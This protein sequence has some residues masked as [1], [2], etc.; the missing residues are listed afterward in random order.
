MSKKIKKESL[1]RLFEK[2]GIKRSTGYYHMKKYLEELEGLGIIEV[3]KTFKN[4]R[5]YVLDE[6][7][8]WDYLK[9]KGFNV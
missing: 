1:W 7:R 9:E 8:F 3:V 4:K 6:N 5:I 2:K